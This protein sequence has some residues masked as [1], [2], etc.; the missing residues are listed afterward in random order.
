MCRL[1]PPDQ[2]FRGGWDESNCRSVCL[3]ISR[4]LPCVLTVSESSP[5]T[6]NEFRPLRSLLLKNCNT[7]GRGW[8][9][10]V[11]KK[12]EKQG[13]LENLEELRSESC[14]MIPNGE[15]SLPLYSSR[16]AR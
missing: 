12:L 15:C 7:I 6:A 14:K 5:P 16:R 4:T 10:G 2:K 3:T 11:L 1:C 8:L 13:D 9:D